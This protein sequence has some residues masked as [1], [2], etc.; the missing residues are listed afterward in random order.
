MRLETAVLM[1]KSMSPTLEFSS[2]GIASSGTIQPPSTSPEASALTRALA[3]FM[4]MNSTSPD[5]ARSDS[6]Q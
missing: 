5:L 6:S 3:S 4:K 2:C 1:P